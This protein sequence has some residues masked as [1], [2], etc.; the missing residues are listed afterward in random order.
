MRAHQER[1]KSNF[2]KATFAGQ[3]GSTR[4]KLA[5]YRSFSF[6]RSPFY[7]APVLMGV[8]QIGAK[9]ISESNLQ[10]PSHAV[11]KAGRYPEA[12]TTIARSDRYRTNHTAHKCLPVGFET[13]PPRI[14][15]LMHAQASAAECPAVLVGQRP[16]DGWW[17][18][19]SCICMWEK[20]AG[21][22]WAGRMYPYLAAARIL[23]H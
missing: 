3:R 17:T 22:L 21:R 11:F 1:C 23:L 10:G 15:P 16:V 19:G 8:Y 18:G 12:V 5:S 4:N 14:P 20:K 6:L 7:S 2:F 13:T 9:S